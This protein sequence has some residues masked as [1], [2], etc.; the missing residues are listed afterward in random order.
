[1]FASR[2]SEKPARTHDYRH[3]HSALTGK[4]VDPVLGSGPR[5]YSGG[6]FL[7]GALI[8]VVSLR[9]PDSD[10]LCITTFPV[11]E[12]TMDAVHHFQPHED[13]DKVHARFDVHRQ[14][15]EERHAYRRPQV[16]RVGRANDLL[17][18]GSSGKY[19]DGYTGYNWER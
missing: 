15:S 19:S 13:H 4:T 11:M 1:M 9:T 3:L 16:V 17:Q 14:T 10:G 12:V 6:R 7:L 18:G 2:S 5:N 8:P